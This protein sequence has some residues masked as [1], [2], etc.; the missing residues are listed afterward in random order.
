M[1]KYTFRWLKSLDASHARDEVI[2]L[3]FRY[4]SSVVHTRRLQSQPIRFLSHLRA[5][6]F[7]FSLCIFSSSPFDKK[8]HLFLRVRWLLCFFSVQFSC[9]FFFFFFAL[10][11]SSFLSL[12]LLLLLSILRYFFWRQFPCVCVCIFLRLVQ[13]S[14]FIVFFCDFFFHFRF[15]P[16]LFFPFTIISIILL[17]IQFASFLN[18]ITISPRYQIHALL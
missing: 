4:F 9:V 17:F 2:S 15:S 8:F 1:F 18:C 3:N 6:S 11:Y 7:S 12:V 16:S 14:L 5:F 13:L 10:V